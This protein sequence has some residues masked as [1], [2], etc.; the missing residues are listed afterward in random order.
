MEPL[1]QRLDLGVERG[2]VAAV[3]DDVIG[4]GDP[5]VARELLGDAGPDVGLV[6]AALLHESLYGDLDR[7]VHDDDRREVVITG[8]RQ[9]WGVEH[10]HVVGAT[11]GIDAT[12]DLRTDRWMH[13]RF[14]VGES[15]VVVERDGGEAGTVERSVSADDVLAEAL[16]KAL[17]QR[18][19][20]LLQLVHDGVGIDDDRTQGSKSPG[21]C[22]FA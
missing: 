17:E 5:L 6:H 10:D 3:V 11:F 2:F 1:P 13:D 19:A 14:E 22:G 4:D 18:R 16:G 21:D 8:D 7:Y 15:T 12:R 20:C 9:Q